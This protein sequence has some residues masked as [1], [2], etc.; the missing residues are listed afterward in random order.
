MIVG[1]VLVEIPG[2]RQKQDEQV[3]LQPRV[4]NREE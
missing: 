4:K 1:S 3:A 2:E